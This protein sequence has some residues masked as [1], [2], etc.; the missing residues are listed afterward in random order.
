MRD[1]S[2]TTG[3]HQQANIAQW[4]NSKP[5]EQFRSQYMDNVHTQISVHICISHQIPPFGA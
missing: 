4:Q 2:R 3:A 5:P 1:K